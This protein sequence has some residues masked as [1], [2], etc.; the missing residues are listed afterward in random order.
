MKNSSS[1][2]PLSNRQP[3]DSIQQTIFNKLFRDLSVPSQYQNG[4]SRE[5]SFLLRTISTEESQIEQL[6][7]AYILE[8]LK[9][10]GLNNQK[11]QSKSVIDQTGEGYSLF[12]KIMGLDNFRVD[13]S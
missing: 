6:S 3:I 1:Q 10:I 8:F 7:K 11:E 9:K 4:L 12:S 5:L 13:L 2:N